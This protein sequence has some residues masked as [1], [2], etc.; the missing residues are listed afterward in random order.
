MAQEEV[1]AVSASENPWSGRLDGGV[2]NVL[3]LAGW[4]K[5]PGHL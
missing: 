4:R 1:L 3:A 5:Y 2:A